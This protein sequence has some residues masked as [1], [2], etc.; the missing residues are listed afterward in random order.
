M[1]VKPSP[2][3]LALAAVSLLALWGT[4]EAHMAGV[5]VL[6]SSQDRIEVRNARWFVAE[7]HAPADETFEAEGVLTVETP[8]DDIQSIFAFFDEDWNPGGFF[9][10]WIGTAGEASVVR[11]QSP[12]GSD[13]RVE[14]PSVEDLGNRSEPRVEKPA[15]WVLGGDDDGTL[16]GYVVALT[17][18]DHP[19]FNLTVAGDGWLGNHT[20]GQDVQ[21]VRVRNFDAVRFHGKVSERGPSVTVDARE[22][23]RIDGS[24]LAGIDLAGD[25]G[26][27]GP[28]DR[29]YRCDART[30]GFEV[31]DHFRM[32]SG[33][34][35]D[36]EFFISRFVGMYGHEPSITVADVERP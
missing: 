16:I 20:Q 28:G 1:T 30:S 3:L 10:S 36:Y 24:L 9:Y 23:I 22:Q 12:T 35:G 25:A 17:Q 18:D 32:L 19:W 26:W 7:A 11:A 8:P 4:G 29:R 27:E 5:E 6:E 15:T 2:A 13:V 31:C 14:S 21:H 34:A 33:P